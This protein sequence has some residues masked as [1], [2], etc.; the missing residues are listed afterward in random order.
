LWPDSDAALASQSLHTLVYSLNSLLGDATL[1]RAAPVVN[2]GGAYRLNT[3]A[4]VG[5]DLARFEA[6]A[7]LGDRQRRA[8]DDVAASIW[9]EAA[10]AL[11]R[12]DLCGGGDVNAAIERERVRALYLTLA[13]RLADFYQQQGNL[14]AALAHALR[15]LHLDPCREDAHRLAMRC[16]VRLGERAQALRQYQ[17]CERI[18]RAEF[19]MAPEAATTALFDQVR[20]APEQV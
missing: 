18:L 17:L 13:A 6:L 3:A 7:L 16:Y 11:Y 8:A 9:Y 20:L 5:V 10:I 1:N 19:E 4:G 14:T 2:E 15:V 12:G